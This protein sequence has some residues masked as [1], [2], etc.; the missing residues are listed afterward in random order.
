MLTRERAPVA[1][2]FRTGEQPL[3]LGKLAGELLANLLQLLARQL[4]SARTLTVTL[5]KLNDGRVTGLNVF[6]TECRGRCAPWLPMYPML[7]ST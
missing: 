1:V 2:A 5:P 3:V 4:A 7:L 6:T